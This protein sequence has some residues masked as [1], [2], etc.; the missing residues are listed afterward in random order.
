MNRYD[1]AIDMKPLAANNEG[2]AL[3]VPGKHTLVDAAS[4]GGSYA[5]HGKLNLA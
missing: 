3:A 5:S 1:K 4:D 2:V